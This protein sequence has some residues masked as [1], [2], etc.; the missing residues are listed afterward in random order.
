MSTYD[1]LLSRNKQFEFPKQYVVDEMDLIDLRR[2][3]MK[4]CAKSQGAIGPCRSCPQKCSAGIRALA[5]YDGGEVPK[6]SEPEVVSSTVEK[7]KKEPVEIKEEVVE[8]TK[9]NDGKPVSKWYKDAVASG[10]PVKWCMDNLGLTIQKAK[11]RIY[12]YEYNRFGV[13][14]TKQAETSAVKSNPGPVIKTDPGPVIKTDS[15]DSSL[16]SAMQTRMK[17]LTEKQQQYKAQ[18]EELTDKYKK[19]NDQIEAI[20]MCIELLNDKVSI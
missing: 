6:T 2:K 20:T 5:L 4:W 17:I 19:V 8:M 10:D 3:I 13:R 16:V 11:K 9:E 14:R 18:I 7:E 15:E 12:M 1:P